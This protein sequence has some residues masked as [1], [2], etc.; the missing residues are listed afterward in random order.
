MAAKS[1]CYLQEVPHYVLPPPWV[2]PLDF[3]LPSPHKNK[4][5]GDGG[6]IFRNP[7]PP[8]GTSVRAMCVKATPK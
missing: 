4:L 3:A 2:P 7:P 5:L 1:Y 6:Q 8:G